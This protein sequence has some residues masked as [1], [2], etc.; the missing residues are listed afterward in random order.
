MSTSLK[1]NALFTR[2][3]MLA[4]IALPALAAAP[5]AKADDSILFKMVRSNGL[6]AGCV[7]NADA[8]VRVQTLG[9]AERMTIIARGLPP[10]TGFD[11]FALQVPNFPFGLSWYIGDLETD[12]RGIAVKTFISRFSKETFAVAVG[13]AKAPRPDQKD[14][15]TNP[16]FKP[17]HTFHLGIWFNAPADAGKAGCPNIV[18]PFNGEHHAGPQV[19]NTRTF[20]DEVGPLRHI[21]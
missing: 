15:E 9:F 1:L 5:Q 3:A 19:L 6:P 14:A 20:S 8:Y 12:A 13:T 18:T 17:I 2:I 16:V 4:A 10:N 11:A 7:P 21:Q